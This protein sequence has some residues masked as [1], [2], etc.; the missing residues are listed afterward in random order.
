MA[1]GAGSRFGGP[2]QTTPVGPHGEWLLEYALFDAIRA[3]FDR[4][5]FI[6]REELE[7]E[8]RKLIAGTGSRLRCDLISQR[9]TELP[10]GFSPGGREKPWGTG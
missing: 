10:P 9:L 1:A 5:V 8:F 2:K 7:P 4:A 6:I 3:G